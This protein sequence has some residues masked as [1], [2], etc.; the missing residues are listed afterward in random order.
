[1]EQHHTFFQW[2]NHN[3]TAI[4]LLWLPAFLFYLRAFVDSCK[5]AGYTKLADKL[6]RFELFLTTFISET[7]IRQITKSVPILFICLGLAFTIGC[8]SSG[9]NGF[10]GRVSGQGLTVPY[11]GGKANVDGFNCHVGCVGKCTPDVYATLNAQMKAY[12]DANTTNGQL[13][14]TGPGIVTFTP[15]K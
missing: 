15:T 7:K 14:T 12:A 9:A 5:V 2:L 1:M 8:A 4:F 10:C 6:G 13:M 11:I 3:S